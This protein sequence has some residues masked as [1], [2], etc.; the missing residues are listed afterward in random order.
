M[1]DIENL[2]D[3]FIQ[4]LRRVYDAEKRLKGIASAARAL[5]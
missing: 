4:N 1:A 2:T 5:M 3:L